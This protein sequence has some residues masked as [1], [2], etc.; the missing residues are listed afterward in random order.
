LES[1]SINFIIYV[2]TPL[3]SKVDPIWQAIQKFV[4]ARQEIQL[5]EHVLTHATI[6][7]WN[8]TEQVRQTL[9]VKHVAH[10]IGHRLQDS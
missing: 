4:P 8:P 10:P 1:H 6:F 3:E 2:H 9:G 7:F 5:A